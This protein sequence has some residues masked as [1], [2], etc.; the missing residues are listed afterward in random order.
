MLKTSTA[1]ILESF[2]LKLNLEKLLLKTVSS[3]FI[4][5]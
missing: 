4:K 5:I 2:I 1:K 3:L